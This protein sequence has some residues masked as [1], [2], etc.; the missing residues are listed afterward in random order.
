[1]LALCGTACIALDQA[2]PSVSET[3]A[4]RRLAR[5]KSDVNITLRRLLVTLHSNGMLRAEGRE[6]PLRLLE[7]TFVA[8]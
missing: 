6:G 1:M 4:N 5:D 3:A 2:M 8:L 7:L